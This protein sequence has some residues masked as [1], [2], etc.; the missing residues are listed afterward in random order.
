MYTQ[1]LK[2]NNI[3]TELTFLLACRHLGLHRG[4]ISLVLY[5]RLKNKGNHPITERLKNK[6][7]ACA[8]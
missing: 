7:K 8:Y 4:N 2:E 3:K 1:R 5:H 6:F